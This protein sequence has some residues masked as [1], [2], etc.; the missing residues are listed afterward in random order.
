M[1]LASVGCTTIWAVTAVILL[2]STTLAV[3]F[4]IILWRRRQ[5]QRLLIVFA[6]GVF[7][8]AGLINSLLKIVIWLRS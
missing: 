8:L 5:K 7:S 3:V 1:D 2:L 4:G 6:L